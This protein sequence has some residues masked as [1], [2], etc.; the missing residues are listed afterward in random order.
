[1]AGRYAGI[2]F[3]PSDL[4]GRQLGRL[5]AQKV[6]QTVQSYFDGTAKPI[7]QEQTAMSSFGRRR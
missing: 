6:W 5:V 3:P 7:V 4:A 1:M 2:H